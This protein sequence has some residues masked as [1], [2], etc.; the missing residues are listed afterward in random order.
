MY[1]VKHITSKGDAKKLILE[2]CQKI[3]ETVGSTMGYRGRTVLNETEGY[4][5]FPTKDGYHTLKQI[6]FENAVQHLACQMIKEAA[7][8]S[9]DESGD[10]TTLTTVLTNAFIKHAQKEVDNGASP[11]DVK[12]A[13]DKSKELIIAELQEYSRHLTDETIF[14]VAKTSANHDLDVAKIVAEAY[15]KAGE[16][17]SVSHVRNNTDETVLVNIPGSLIEQ[18][19]SNECYINI[20]AERSVFYDNNPLVLVSNISFKTIQQLVPFLEYCNANQRPLILI[21]DLDFTVES[22]IERNR[23]ENKMPVA[24]IKP[25]FNGQ[26]RRDLLK[27]IATLC[28]TQVIQ[29]ESGSYFKDNFMEYLGMCEDITITKRDTIITPM[30]SQKPVIE[31]KIAELKEQLLST[32]INL[33]KSYIK[34]RISRLSGGV[35]IIKVGGYTESERKEL[36]DRVDDAVCAVRSAKEG[37]IVAGGGCALFHISENKKGEL[38]AVTYKAIREPLAQ[39]LSNASVENENVLAGF[40][41]PYGYDVKDFEVVNMFEKGIVDARKVIVSALTNSI[42]TAT[43]LLMADHVITYAREDKTFN[44]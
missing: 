3:A 8:K 22:I 41:Y 44:Q 26:K 23:I 34:E 9:V 33:E 10:G 1:P 7:Q 14:D 29:L 42:S 24:V 37:G 36:I 38:D 19:Y 13:I 32:D 2:S 40:N 39:I 25:P 21:S 31:S 5:P 16:N 43:T 11:I 20:L 12:N 4:L 15:I 6:F 27:D 17:G 35:S 30:E 18:G 28:N